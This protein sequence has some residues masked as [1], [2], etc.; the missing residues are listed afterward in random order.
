MKDLRISIRLSEKEHSLFKIIS[1]K[2]KKSM[3]EL[4]REY[5]LKEIERDNNEKVKKN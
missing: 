4:L 3:Q 5:V 2:K 1:I